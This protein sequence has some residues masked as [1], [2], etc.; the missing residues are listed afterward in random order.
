MTN[1]TNNISADISTNGEKLEEVTSIK[2]L[3]A[4]LSKDGTC[5]AEVVHQDY[6]GSNG[7][8]KQDLAVQYH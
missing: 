8:T 5:S 6:L 7:Q 4:T 3:A 1:S 2:Y